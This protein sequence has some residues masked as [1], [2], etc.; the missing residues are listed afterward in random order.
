MLYETRPAQV[1]QAYDQIYRLA[2]EH[3]A[4]GEVCDD[5]LLSWYNVKAWVVGRRSR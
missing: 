2:L 5:F 4:S 1:R 3:H